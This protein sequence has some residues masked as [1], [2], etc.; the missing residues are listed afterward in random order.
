MILLVDKSKQKQEEKYKLFYN[1]EDIPE[2]FLRNDTEIIN[3]DPVIVMKPIE[4]FKS[5]YDGC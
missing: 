5:F 3:I 4:N 1:K 2:K